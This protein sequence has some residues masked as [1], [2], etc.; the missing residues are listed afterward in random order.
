MRENVHLIH[1]LSV[2]QVSP[3]YTFLNS[4]FSV[5]STS[6]TT[7]SAGL[8]K[9]NKQNQ[10]RWSE[11]LS[12]LQLKLEENLHKILPLLKLLG[13]LFRPQQPKWNLVCPFLPENVKIR[14]VSWWKKHWY[15]IC[16]C[17]YAF[18]K[19]RTWPNI[20]QNMHCTV[21]LNRI[22]LSWTPWR[23]FSFYSCRGLESLVQTGAKPIKHLSNSKFGAFF[24]PNI[25]SYLEHQTDLC[26]SRPLDEHEIHHY[27][28]NLDL[29]LGP[30]RR[31]AMTQLQYF[32]Y[33]YL[34]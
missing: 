21:M 24:S 23:R 29:M 31:Q 17:D 28:F 16:L 8:T 26:S 30:T 4:G 25:I 18:F 20:N 3:S 32:L 11:I 14:I 5:S 6:P 12:L 27:I 2:S 13:S 1:T 9:Y 34:I 33:I 15:F 10:S 22:V 19:Y 7:T